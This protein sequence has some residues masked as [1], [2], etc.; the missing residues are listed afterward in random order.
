ML[1]VHGRSVHVTDPARYK[2]KS[3]QSLVKTYN[4]DLIFASECIAN[5]CKKSVMD[6]FPHTQHCPICVRVEPVV[7]PQ[8]TPFRRQ[9][10]LRKA[11]WI[12]YATELDKLILD[13]EPTPAN[14]NRFV[15]RV[16]MASRS[17]IPRECRTEVIPCLTKESK[18]LYEAYKTQ[19]SNSPFDDGV[20][21]SGNALLDSIIKEKKRRWEEVITSTNM[22]HNS[23]QAWKT[24]RMLSNDPTSSSPPC[25]VNANQVAHQLL[26]NGRG[27]ISSK[28]KRPVLPETR[29]RYL[30]GITFQ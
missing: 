19:Y 17:H 8:A 24:I 1:G 15:E 22:S 21:A 13:V 28:P 16:R 14:Y 3:S 23:R 12:G 30:H 5:S 25:I 2:T 6:P 9:F 29:G 10:N 4:P 20:M 11:D 26:L 27:N 7:V 18:S